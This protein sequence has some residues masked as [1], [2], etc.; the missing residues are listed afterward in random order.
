MSGAT[1][2][3]STGTCW[4]SSRRTRPGLADLEQAIRQYLAWKSIVEEKEELNL[5]AFQSRQAETKK[6]QAEEAVISR[7]QE[8]YMWLLVPAQTD[9]GPVEWED[10]R[11]QGDGSLADRAGAKLVSEELLITQL[12]GN[13]LRMDLDEF[14]LGAAETMSD[15]G[16]C[17]RI[18]PP[19][20]T[21]PD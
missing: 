21:S 8:T 1:A 15:C 4:C 11:L 9:Q 16:K 6:K 12:A 3:A 18:S 10:F 2:R 19:T 14:N 17:G 5:D 7:I 13:R 20:C